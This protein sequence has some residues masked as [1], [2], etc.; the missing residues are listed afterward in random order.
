MKRREP[1]RAARR[2]EVPPTPRFVPPAYNCTTLHRPRLEDR[3]VDAARTRAA[4]VVS[5]PA[6][7][8]KTLLVATTCR[9]LETTGS[10]SVWIHLDARDN[11]YDRLVQTLDAAF[12]PNDTARR[13]RFGRVRGQGTA[14][15]TYTYLVEW[16][17]D[18][19]TED[20]PIILV[21]DDYEVVDDPA[22]HELLDGL[23]T[24]FIPNVHIIVLSRGKPPL[25]LSTLRHRRQLCEIGRE[26]LAFT[27]AEIAALL[28][29]EFLLE[30]TPDNLAVIEA[31][32]E[33]W[34]VAVQLVGMALSHRSDATGF[35]EGLSGCDTDVADFLSAEVL[36]RQPPELV[37]FLLRISP[38]SRVCADLCCAVTGSADS[39][40]LLDEIVR[41]NLLLFPIDRN[42]HWFRFHPLFREFLTAQLPLHP[43]ISVEAIHHSA[44][45]WC[46]ENDEPAD[47]IN[48]ALELRDPAI[49]A[50]L[51]RQ[52]AERFV[53]TTGDHSLFLAWMARL[54]DRPDEYGFELKYWQAWALSISHRLEE[55]ESVLAE[56]RAY[57]D[58][59][60]SGQ[61]DQTLAARTEIIDIL[62]ALFRDRLSECVQTTRKWLDRHPEAAPFDTCSIATALAAAASGIGEFAL[63]RSALQTARYTAEAARSPYAENWVGVVEGHV[64]M[65][66]GDY[67]F[68]HTVLKHQ[69]EATS[70][71]LG[72]ASSALSTVS[73]LLS[74]TCYALGDTEAA[75]KYLKFGLPHINDHGLIESAAAGFRVM[76]RTRERHGGYQEA[77]KAC[78]DC[79][80]IAP[81]YGP[82]LSLH[83]LNEYVGLLL[84]HDDTEKATEA[85]GFDGRRFH[86][87][88]LADAG[89]GDDTSPL[90]AALIKGRILLAQDRPDAALEIL[91]PAIASAGRTH[92]HAHRIEL[93]TLR[94]RAWQGKGRHRRACRSLAEAVNDAASL[95]M[96]QLFLDEGP[97]IGRLLD[98]VICQLAD[99]PGIDLDFLRRIG[100]PAG[101]PQAAVAAS[102][103]EGLAAESLA[104]REV[105]ILRLLQ[106]GLTNKEVAARLFLSLKTVKWYLYNL[107]PK[108]G[109]KNRTGAL[110]KARELDLI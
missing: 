17:E 4:T 100:M 94:G 59:R 37:E 84:R 68:A 98:E 83:L 5:A 33:G 21:L 29:R 18:L 99:T 14:G 95:G 77:L 91:S 52:H 82:R 8:G 35:I 47:A 34:P 110:A 85:A 54:P 13:S 103:E 15:G 72:H 88:A 61:P 28:E 24:S 92:R 7:Y 19:A 46:E 106:A 105:E 3:L 12:R 10:R 66:T 44:M 67:R 25:S 57:V 50:R 1:A 22:I 51:L 11:S 20:S 80:R 79:E 26:S 58:R 107:Y 89:N 96:V 78:F 40:R 43:E 97:A 75:V 86:N 62:I 30:V 93:L 45:A 102:A 63:A 41:S 60:E 2:S 90:V 38:L 71:S 64:A 16:L 65:S 81:V 9:R 27:G 39:A 6:G 69:F 32:T 31:R 55:A 109:V 23:I 76:I 56:L 70:R 101:Q 74:E 36:A 108:L 53:Y 48:Y 42:N 49:A 73:L 104:P 87:P